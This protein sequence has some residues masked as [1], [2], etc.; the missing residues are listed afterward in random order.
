LRQ[1]STSSS[2]PTG[3]T[4]SM[5]SPS[6][7]TFRATR[8]PSLCLTRDPYAWM[9]DSFAYST[10]FSWDGSQELLWRDSSK[11]ALLNWRSKFNEKLFNI[12]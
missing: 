5:S 9:E 1:R 8:T 11:H 7:R 3:Q 2:G 6:F 12:S 10:S 4:R